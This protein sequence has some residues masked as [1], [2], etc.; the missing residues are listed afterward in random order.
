M[1]LNLTV[2][3][4]KNLPPQEAPSARIGTAGGTIGRSPDSDL[5]LPDSERWVSGQ[6]ARIHFRNGAYY[7]TDT[8]KNGTFVN[9]TDEP[10]RQG[11]EVELHDGDELNIGGYE[12]RVSLATVEPSA[13]GPFDP[14]AG[15]E[16]VSEPLDGLPS[17][18]A[19]PDILDLVGPQREA[20]EPSFPLEKGDK[21]FAEPGDWL[22]VEAPGDAPGAPDDSPQPPEAPAHLATPDHTPDQNAFFRPPSAVPE[23]YDILSDESNRAADGVEAWPE[24]PQPTPPAAGDASAQSSYREHRRESASAEQTPTIQAGAEAVAEPTELEAFLAGLETGELPTD[25]AA[26]ARLMR[27]AGSLLRTMTSGLMQVMMAR[28]RFKSELRLEMTTIRSTEN[29]PF[30]FSVDADD[31]LDHLLFRPSR[32]FLSP[33]D[34]AREAFGDIQR[35]EMA[36]VAGLRAALRALLARMD[37]GEMEQRFRDRSVFDNLLPMARKAKYWDLFTE[38]YD[39]VAADAAEDFLHLFGEAFTRAYEDQTSRLKETG[40]RK[41]PLDER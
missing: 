10:L 18:E 14:F 9:Q 29:N 37:P 23:N 39:Q 27:T 3:R 34:A 13:A 17:G 12:I 31:A 15:A 30:K 11:E 38:T 24:A 16:P 5:A 41:E 1:D 36:I 33:Q 22:S 35:H 25:P 21:G 4:Y 26:R 20:Q 28:A 2:I 40:S 32:G 19:A 8:S 6:H 7:L